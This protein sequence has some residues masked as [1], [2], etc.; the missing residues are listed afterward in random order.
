VADQRN[1]RN[2]EVSMAGAMKHG[3]HK[4]NSEP[5]DSVRAVILPQGS[6]FSLFQ[7]LGGSL[8]YG[9]WPGC[10]RFMELDRALQTPAP[11]NIP[12]RLNKPDNSG[13]PRQTSEC[14]ASIASVRCPNKSDSTPKHVG[15]KC[16]VHPSERPKGNVIRG[17]DDLA[18]HRL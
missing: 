12:S 4:L 18:I 17:L 6:P 2:E 10:Q 9:G 7:S 5:P 3:G 16:V 13:D 14:S 1:A 11:E 15:S 8:N